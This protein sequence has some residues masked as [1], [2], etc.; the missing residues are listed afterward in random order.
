MLVI[1][2]IKVEVE[3]KDVL[4]G[5][6]LTV[7]PG[8]VHVIVG[9]N[10]SGKG[11]LANT[12]IG[13]PS[14]ALRG[15]SIM[16]DGEDL[17]TFSPERRAQ[18]GIFM[19]YQ[20]PIAIPGMSL[21]SFLR[22]IVGAIRDVQGKEALSTTELLARSRESSVSLGLPENFLER[23]L[24][25][26]FSGGE[27]KRVEMLQMALLEPKLAI[28]DE[29]DSGLD[30]D[31]LSIIAKFLKGYI[32]QERAFI[33][34]SHYVKLV[35]LL[36]VTHVHLFHNGNIAASGGKELAYKIE[37]EGYEKLISNVDDQ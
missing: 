8:E 18:A 32:S 20:S 36:P 24:N 5:V 22:T 10:G 11:S 15:G 6:S 13:N 37:D 17:T 33:I 4:K 2:N 27:K 25:V 26:G 31:A 9:Q 3:G 1:D 30:R 28:L 14:Y 35:E 34:I 7:Q 19:G 21:I 23:S 29:I 12:I 16:F